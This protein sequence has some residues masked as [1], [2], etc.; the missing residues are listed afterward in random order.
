MAIFP[1]DKAPGK[2]CEF[3]NPKPQ[4]G[5]GC[6]LIQEEQHNKRPKWCYGFDCLWLSSSKGDMPDSLAPHKVKAVM[7][8]SKVSP[9]VHPFEQMIEV[10]TEDAGD[11][12][13]MVKNKT[14]RKWLM[15][16]CQQG[17]IICV[18]NSENQIK[19]YYPDV[20]V[21]VIDLPTYEEQKARYDDTGEVYS[22]NLRS[23]EEW[24]GAGC[25]KYTWT[26]DPV[27]HAR[28]RKELTYFD[29]F[30]ALADTVDTVDTVNTVNTVDTVDK[31]EE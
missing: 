7:N 8:I 5:C 10:R 2:W 4:D 3:A 18:I 26:L 22:M 31:Q 1:L 6:V 13:K 28:V 16:R 25:D 19:I 30:A 14:L 17:L 20:A 29:H 24:A 21:Q 15:G 9:F 27:T 12:D 11:H 23:F